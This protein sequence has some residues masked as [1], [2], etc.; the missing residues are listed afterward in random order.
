VGQV[1]HGWLPGTRGINSTKRDIRRNQSLYTA[2]KSRANATS[3]T[4]LHGGDFFLRGF[5][6][7]KTLLC[8]DD[9]TIGLQ[10]RK[11]ILERQGYRVLTA[12]E[13]AAGL[14]VFHAHEVDAVVLDYY[15]PGM[16]GGTV[17]SQMK[18]SKPGVPIILLSAFLT[19]PESVMQSVDA[20]IVKG[21]SPE[22]LLA[23]IAELTHEPTA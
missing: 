10:V 14:D 19:M 11:I 20:F 17:A 2:S 5:V 23:K 21:D 8:V 6:P 16:N 15:M 9:E 4:R 1:N 22:V 12:T 7:K 3:F 18:L 13:G